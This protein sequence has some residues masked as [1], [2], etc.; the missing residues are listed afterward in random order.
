MRAQD[1]IAYYSSMKVAPIYVIL[2]F[3]FKFYEISVLMIN[4]LEI[5]SFLFF[6]FYCSSMIRINIS[7]TVVPFTIIRH[8]NPFYSFISVPTHGEALPFPKPVCEGTHRKFKNTETA[9]PV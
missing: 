4:Y 9:M 8:Q 7:L 2:K 1:G 6:S 5:L 3:Y